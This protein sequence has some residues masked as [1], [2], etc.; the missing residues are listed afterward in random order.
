MVIGDV[1]HVLVEPNGWRVG[2]LEV[3]LSNDVAERIGAQKRL[4]RS[5]LIEI[6][7]EQIQSLGDAVIL[8]VPVDALRSA[9]EPSSDEAPVAP[10]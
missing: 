6:P 7:T 1:T 10:M 3:R 9:S 4:L 2:A 5:T 8:S